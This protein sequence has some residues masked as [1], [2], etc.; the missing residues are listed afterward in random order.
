MRGGDIHTAPHGAAG[1]L[2]SVVGGGVNA[3]TPSGGHVSGG[4]A[5]AGRDGAAGRGGNGKLTRTTTTT[6]FDLT[7]DPA[8]LKRAMTEGRRYLLDA[9]R[10]LFFLALFTFTSLT[11]ENNQDLYW[12]G[13]QV[14][15]FFERSEL[16]SR[17]EDFPVTLRDI[18]AEHEVWKYVSGVFYPTLYG[19]AAWD[20]DAA[21]KRSSAHVATGGD[22]AWRSDSNNRQGWVMGGARLVG[23]VRVGT[24][25]VTPRFAGDDMCEIAPALG[26]FSDTNDKTPWKCYPPFQTKTTALQWLLGDPDTEVGPEVHHLIS[27]FPA[28]YLDPAGRNPRARIT[29]VLHQTLQGY[30]SLTFAYLL[31]VA[32]LPRGQNRVRHG[33][34][35]SC[36][37]DSERG[38]VE[39]QSRHKGAWVYGLSYDGRVSLAG[40]H[41]GPAQQRISRMPQGFWRRGRGAQRRARLGNRGGEMEGKDENERHIGHRRVDRV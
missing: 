21:F 31:A 7:D 30:G 20:F 16:P 36:V 4:I 18:R 12:L 27:S 28:P 1:V 24:I 40:L 17:D 29:S 11:S 2:S 22:T 19:A 13:G 37:I 15:E 14:S 10:F 25:R 32:L 35:H 39:V 8:L 6:T 5:S 9:L 26:G 3:L 41:C 38:P 33:A 34:W 23:G